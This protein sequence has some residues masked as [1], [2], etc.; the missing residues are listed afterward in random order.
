M[1]I[2]QNS[3]RWL[4]KLTRAAAL[5]SLAL[6]PVS[7]YSQDGALYSGAQPSGGASESTGLNRDGYGLQFRGGHVAGDTV[8][9]ND[10]ISFIGLSPYFSAGNSLIFGDTR[11]GRANEGGLVWSFGSGYRYYVEDWDVVLGGNGYYDRDH[12]SGTYL[13]QW[14]VGAEVLGHA[15]ELR[16]NYYQ[17][18]GESFALTSQTVKPGSSAFTGSNL[19]F[20]RTDAFSEGLQGFDAEAGILL[21]G[22]FA[23][24]IDLRAFGGGYYYEGDVAAGFAGWSTRLQADIRE[25]FELG[26]KLTNDEQF[27][28]TVSFT[29]AVHFGGFRSQ[30]HLKR[31][32]IQRFREPVRRNLNVVTLV[33]SQDAP[34]QLALDPTTGLPLSIAHVNSNDVGGPFLGT[35]N[36][37]YRLLQQG[38]GAGTDLVYVHA[39]S[40]FSAGPE[41]VVN[42]LPGQQLIGEGELT[43]GRSTQNFVTVR[44]AGQLLQVELPKSPTFAAAPNLARPD[45]NGSI[46]TAVRLADDS[47]FSG[48]TITNPTLRGIFSNGAENTIVND[49]KISGAGESAIVLAN[50]KGY[51]AI[52]NTT[53]QSSATASGPLMLVS[54]GNGLVTF[55]ST[56]NLL[57]GSMSNTSGNEALIVENMI[58]G[59]FTMS[60]SSITDDGGEGVVIRNNTGGTAVIDNL[61]STNAAVSGLQILN[62]AGSYSFINSSPQV[63]ALTID[64]SGQQS[65]LID[66]LSGSATFNS[67]VDITNRNAGGIEI[68]NSSGAVRFSK[69]VTLTDHLGAGAEAGILVSNN[70][71]GSS[72]EFSDTV[73]ITATAIVAGAPERTEGNGILISNNAAG[74]L[75]RT[76][77]VTTVNGTDLASVAVSSNSGNVKFEGETRVTNRLA[78]G[79]QVTGSSG[80]IEFG[81]GTPRRLTQVNNELVS[82]SAAI[83]VDGNSGTVSFG[84]AVVVDA[85][86]N[87]GGGAGI[88]VRNN[89][90]LVN[91]TDMS[92]TSL[93]G[94]GFFGLDNRL[95]RASDGLIT[96]TDE[97]A[98]DI[99]NSGIEMTL[100]QVNSSDAPDYGIRLVETNK[101]EGRSFIIR[102]TANTTVAGNGGTISGAKG[103]GLDNN[104]AAGI[105]L[106]NAGQVQI[107]EMILTDNEFGVRIENT[108]SYQDSAGNVNVVND[109]D[110][111]FFLMQFSLV[112]DSDIRGIHAVD[113]MGLQVQDTVFDNNGDDTAVG[114]DTI[115]SEYTVALDDVTVVNTYERSERP[116]EVLVERSDFTS[117]QHDVIRIRQTAGA[118]GA[119]IRTQFYNNRIEANDSTDPGTVAPFDARPLLDDGISMDWNG[120]ARILVE[121]NSFDMRAATDQMAFV[122]SNTSSTD[123]TEMSLQTN[124]IFVNNLGTNP[125]AVSVDLLGDYQMGDVDGV[126]RIANNVFSVAGQTPTAMYFVLPPASTA[127]IQS[128]LF[129]GNQMTLESD[130]GTGI[131]IRRAGNGANLSFAANSVSFRDLGNAAERGF[132]VAPVSGP[133]QLSGLG[134]QMQ[135]ISNGINGNGFIEALLLIPQ[136]S[137]IGQTQINGQLLP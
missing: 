137:A 36:D 7:A 132:V 118:S 133:V 63:A 49:V 93:A 94:T 85:T 97:T 111:Q 13:N 4:K 43:A 57:F 110:E 45:L 109:R 114:Y 2:V 38:L 102:P 107:R 72:V 108:E 25:M 124:Q 8:G 66:G 117:N 37:P 74:S 82:G 115:Y 52:S 22:D 26:L 27:D 6:G 58:G 134:N 67:P 30:E 44:A 123:L 105:Y 28:T 40:S 77:G 29:A 70:L 53:L 42:L 127:R 83:S 14:G 112:N 119:A 5:M 10:S 125:G 17:T 92:V 71:A 61:V 103:D 101:A 15:W 81:T 95:I 122:F 79:V 130:G 113:L 41:N 1:K 59:Q 18:F 68:T 84:E 131:E 136:G 16:G 90:G 24:R 20:T 128:A 48:F 88:D 46:G 51:T 100:E 39:G 135:V 98:V 35:V 99:E 116:F 21:P 64:A 54:G 129:Q 78:E 89:T 87:P 56:D 34:G 23:E 106:A 50:T 91:F 73:D 19:T 55:T 120:P 31:S 126:Y 33:T 76:L 9:R 11:L 80:T 65:I 47:Q 12:L 3:N 32:A 86:G 121:G 69:D 104:D 60:R 62:S 96:T 75:V